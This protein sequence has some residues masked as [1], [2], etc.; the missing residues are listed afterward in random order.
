MLNAQDA[1]KKNLGVCYKFNMLRS[2]ADGR[3]I[4]EVV[5]KIL[6]EQF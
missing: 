1:E 4:S 5:D 6:S 2:K 3:L